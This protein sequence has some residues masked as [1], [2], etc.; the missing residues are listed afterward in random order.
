[1]RRRRDRDHDGRAGSPEPVSD[2][3][4]SL[5]ERWGVAAKVER[6]RAVGDWERVAGPHIA[7]VTGG[8]RVRGRSLFVEVHGAAWLYELNM[9]RHRLL[10][11]LN[12]GKRPRARL[13][14]L[15]FVQADGPPPEPGDGGRDDS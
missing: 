3:V 14:R 11:R 1:M 8:V 6:A 9:M 7:R 5:L 10:E 4:S 13:E 2:L 15:V 12:E